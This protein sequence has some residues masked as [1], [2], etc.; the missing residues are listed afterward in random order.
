MSD[1]F[2]TQLNVTGGL[3][4][5]QKVA[6]TIMIVIAIVVIVMWWIRTT[7]KDVVYVGPVNVGPHE[8]ISPDRQW[9]PLMTA[10]QIAKKTSNNITCSFFLYVNASSLNTIPTNY[11]GSYKFNYVVTIGNTLGIVVDPTKQMC[12]VDILQAAPH[13][14]RGDTIA[15]KKGLGN[16]LRTLDVKGILISKWN[17]LTVCVEGRTVDVYLNGKLQTSAILDNVPISMFS[18]LMLNGSPDFDGQVCL[19]QMWPERRTGQQILENYQ[20]NTDLRGRPNVPDPE[21]TLSGAWER[22]KKASCEKVGICGLSIP[23]KT[24]ALEWVEYEIA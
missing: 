14:P 23:V 24:S 17:Q 15:M 2:G 22:F 9:I 19:F 6:M 13:N 11:D 16:I 21:L 5:R 12:S 18:G 3:S 10:D 8:N 20:R 7:P 1:Y 4:T